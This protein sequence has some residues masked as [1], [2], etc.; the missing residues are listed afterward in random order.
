LMPT[1]ANT[2]SWFEHVDLMQVIL[3]AAMGVIIFMFKR[4]LDRSDEDRKVQT[5][6]NEDLYTK[7]STLRSDFD[8]LKGEHKANTSGGR[9][10]YDPLCRPGA[11][12]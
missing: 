5:K 10:E 6:I 1:P 7:H 8:E 2:P 12:K 3:V 9:R 4:W 11:H